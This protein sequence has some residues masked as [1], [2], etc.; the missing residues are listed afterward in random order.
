MLGATPH[1]CDTAVIQSA[2]DPSQTKTS[3]GW[4]LAATILGSS[5]VFI[6]GTVV[7][8]ALPALQTQFNASASGAQWVIQSYALFLAALLLVGGAL[9]D[10][11]GR[12]RVFSIGVCVFAGASV[13]CGLATSLMQLIVARGVQGVGAA[14]LA[15]GS[16]AI[17]GAS[18]PE[19]T[20]GRAIGTWSGAT[21]ITAAIGPALGG[22]LIDHASWR[23]A[24]F[25]NVPIAIAVFLIAAR[26]VPESRNPGTTKLDWPGAALATLGLCGIV[27]GL[28]EAPDRGWHDT[29]V[30]ATLVAGVVALMA[31]VLVEARS[32]APMLPLHLFRLRD[33]SG[34]NLLTLLLY[35][36]LGGG[37]FFFPINLIQVQGY[38]A[39]AAGAAL[40]PFIA[41]MVLFSRWAGGLVAR[42][43]AKLPLSI[44]PT[45]AAIGYLLLSLPGIGGSYWTTFFPATLV[46]GFGM[47]VSVAPLTTVVMNTVGRDLAGLASGVNNAVSRT[48]TLLAIALLGVIMAHQFSHVLERHLTS[49]EH[50][51]QPVRDAVYAQRGKLAGIEI[52]A[53]VDEE[54][55]ATV[56]LAIK[57]SY[58]SGF[59][60]LMR[61]CAALAL[62][63]VVPGWILISGKHVAKNEAEQRERR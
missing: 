36:A 55:R 30:I 26:F 2:D 62:L 29:T 21:G 41:V 63:A 34:A 54:V 45:I 13:C 20:R 18:F 8:V 22:W 60:L 23:W 32:H 57:Q 49:L 1:P 40:L 37:L 61:I 14:L 47:A 27:Y 43:G 33:F 11:Y 51:S 9:G 16:L 56:S 25:I 15:P 38:S 48:A 5:M 3:P 42:Y 35:G 39:T 44:G 50:A 46:M 17:I 31:F 6:D 24:F 4:I 7:N 52:P 12:R 59:R 58:V 19:A 10:R 53:D 28:M